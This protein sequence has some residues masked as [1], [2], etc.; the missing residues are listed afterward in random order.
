MSLGT[1]LGDKMHRDIVEHKLLLVE[2]I[3]S[4]FQL[5][6]KSNPGLPYCDWSK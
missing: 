6:I 5:S 1:Q 3:E 2:P 4:D